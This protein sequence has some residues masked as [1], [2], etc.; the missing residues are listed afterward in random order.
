MQLSLLWKK[1]SIIPTGGILSTPAMELGRAY[2]A[3]ELGDVCCVELSSG[4]VIWRFRASSAVYADV[5]IVDDLVIVSS[6]NGFIYALNKSD[7]KK[8]WMSLT[9]GPITQA[10]SVQEGLLYVGTQSGDLCCIDSLNSEIIWTH[11]VSKSINYTPAVSGHR[12]VFCDRDNSPCCLDTNS[13]QIDWQQK[14]VESMFSDIA[15]T[16]PVIT[17]IDNEPE[18]K[19]FI[20]TFYEM[21]CIDLSTGHLDWSFHASGEIARKPIVCR[22]GVIFG[23]TY[24]KKVYSLDRRSGDL[25]WVASTE[26][27]ACSPLFVTDSH[28]LVDSDD[29]HLYCFEAR[30]G[31]CE[32]KQ[33]F[34]YGVRRL[35]AIDNYLLLATRYKDV[36]C[37]EMIADERAA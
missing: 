35:N 4:E 24:G 20:G 23:D 16:S 29:D 17:K 7:G 8:V 18:T 1:N 6:T 33:S 32:W 30:L 5:I 9:S 28:I 21:C 36:Y 10:P 37:Y 26:G 2:L 15:I 34:Q 12:V 27:S 14:T 13:M 3:S 31:E 11:C 25:Q 22:L 19:V